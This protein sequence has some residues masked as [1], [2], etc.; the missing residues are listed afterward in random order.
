M[1]QSP[2]AIKHKRKKTVRKAQTQEEMLHDEKKIPKEQLEDYKKRK[3]ITSNDK[4]EEKKSHLKGHKSK[5][6]SPKEVT[7]ETEPE[8]I[9][10]EGEYW[11]K[12]TQR[13]IVENTSRFT[14]RLLQGAHRL[15]SRMKKK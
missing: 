6:T 10:Q 13:Q 1:K 9:H 11:I 8:H 2:H 15:V 14:K 7:F 3:F 4:L 5:R 12:R